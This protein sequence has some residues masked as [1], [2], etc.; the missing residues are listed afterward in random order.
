[1]LA[2]P[3]EQKNEIKSTALFHHVKRCE[4]ATKDLMSMQMKNSATRKTCIST[5]AAVG[6]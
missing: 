1:M 5:V 6:S 3:I 2:M 4:E